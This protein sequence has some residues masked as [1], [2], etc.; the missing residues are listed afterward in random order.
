MIGKET[1]EKGA[2]KSASHRALDNKVTH[3]DLALLRVLAGVRS[4]ERA[5]SRLVEIRKTKKMNQD[6]VSEV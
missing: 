4:R 5:C 2:I 6:T 1:K 3:S